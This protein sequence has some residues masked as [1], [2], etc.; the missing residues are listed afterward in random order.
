MITNLN[1]IKA[2]F[3]NSKKPLIILISGVPATGK[4][5]LALELAYK[6]GIKVC[7][8]V[9]EIKEIVKVYDQNP[10]IRCSSHDAWRLIGKRTKKNI[11]LGFKRYCLGFQLGVMSIINRSER[12][13]ENLIIEGV[14]LLPNYYKLNNKFSKIHIILESN[15]GNFLEKNIKQKIAERHGRQPNVWSEKIPEFKNIQNMLIK[16]T[17]KS[18]NCFV[19]PE[20][21]IEKNLDRILKILEAY[22]IS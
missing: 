1:K 5:T 12:N 9:D 18:K 15:L 14:H 16:Q 2:K 17:K 13:G 21:K 4:S 20:D 11:L 7:L 19:L 22:E 3:N 8:G 10:Y 6:L